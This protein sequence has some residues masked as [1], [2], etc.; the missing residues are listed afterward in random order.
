MADSK[1]D[2]YDWVKLALD[3]KGLIISAIGLIISAITNGVQ[4]IDIQK[5]DNDIQILGKSYAT[6]VYQKMD[7]NPTKPAEKPIEK[8]I[9][10]NRCADECQKIMADH[11]KEFH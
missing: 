8:T 10:I 3:N 6:L 9:Y 2:H 4:A 5:K 1:H 7:I 11:I